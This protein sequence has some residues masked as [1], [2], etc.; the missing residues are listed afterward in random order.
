[1]RKIE[2]F[3]SRLNTKIDVL[4]FVDVNNMTQYID[5]T[6][7]DQDFLKNFCVY[8]NIF[9]GL[10]TGINAGA[11]LVN[12]AVTDAAGIDISTIKTWDD[13]IAAGEK[14]HAY[15]PNKY[16][17][18]YEL[19]TLG[20]EFIFTNL[21]QLTGKEIMDMEDYTLN[22]TRDDLYKV[23]DLID[24]LY[25]SKTLQPVEESILY[26][27]APWTNPKWISH[28][29]AAAALITSYINE[30]TYDFQDTADI[31]PQPVWEGAKESGVILRPTQIIGVVHTCQAPEEA[32]KF[33][34]YF[35][36]DENAA[37]TLRDVRS[38][39]PTEKARKICMDEGLLDPM[40]VKAVNLALPIATAHQ[41][42]NV[43]EDIIQIFKDSTAKV[44]YKMET[45]GAITDETMER[46]ENALTRL[47]RRLKK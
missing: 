43:P 47:E 30:S 45:V 19:I 7:F 17:L 22:F 31:L 15:D 35:F 16:F 12:T 2:H 18:N 25:S 38:I 41:N 36:N 9:V 27:T 21:A 4:C 28:D 34:D 20:K 24:R 32:F 44:A 11:F 33:L 14:L 13:L 6:G 8:D 39:P 1:M 10:P 5:L 23:F 29:F 46:L 42:L 26:D 37:R 3:L 40:A